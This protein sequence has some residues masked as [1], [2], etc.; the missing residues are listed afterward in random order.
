[1]IDNC[2][3]LQDP[4]QILAPQQSQDSQGNA[5]TTWHVVAETMA[6]ARDLSGQEFFSAAQHQMKNVMNFKIRWRAGLTCGMHIRYAGAEYDIIQVNHLGNRRRGYMLL[7]GS[8]IQGE[9][10]AYGNL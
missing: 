7:R 3:E 1:M 9:G 2:G 6:Q 4:I 10:A 8:L 5:I